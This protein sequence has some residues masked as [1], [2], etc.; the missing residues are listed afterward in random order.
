[1]KRYLNFQTQVQIRGCMFL[2]CSLLMAFKLYAQSGDTSPFPK[3]ETYALQAKTNGQ[4]YRLFVSLPDSYNAKDSVHYPVL[5]LLDGNP[6]FSLLQSMQ[7]FFVTGEEVPEMII[8][9]IGYPV[10]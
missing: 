9:G 8:V 5:Y 6:F 1:M 2:L 3:T 10:K 7:R 4:D